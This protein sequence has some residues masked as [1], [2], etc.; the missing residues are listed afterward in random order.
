MTTESASAVGGTKSGGG[1][2]R[3]RAGVLERP[4]PP[5]QVK[6]DL[7]P[8]PPANQDEEELR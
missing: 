6:L 7:P 8:K 3:L 1:R 2:R 4:S 5:K